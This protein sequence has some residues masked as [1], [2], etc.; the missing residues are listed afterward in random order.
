MLEDRKDPTPSRREIAV[1]ESLR[2]LQTGPETFPQGELLPDSLRD[3]FES[4]GVH[5]VGGCW[6]NGRGGLRRATAKLEEMAH[7]AE[8]ATKALQHYLDIYTAKS[9]SVTTDATIDHAAQV[10]PDHASR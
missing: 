3:W 8:E 5:R 10:P 1:R 4:H 7:H 6:F 9:D 2:T